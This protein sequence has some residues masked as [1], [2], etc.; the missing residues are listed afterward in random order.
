MKNI[1]AAIIYLAMILIGA[2]VFH[3]GVRRLEKLDF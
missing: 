3:D 2:F 1:I